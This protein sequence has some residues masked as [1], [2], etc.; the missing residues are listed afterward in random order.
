MFNS[1]TYSY[2]GG[3][4]SSTGIFTAPKSG[5]YLFTYNIKLTTSG[6]AVVSLIMNGTIITQAVVKK[7]ANHNG[8]NTG[9]AYVTKG[10]KVWVQYRIYTRSEDKFYIWPYRTTFNG[11]LID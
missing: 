10:G 6:E 5:T 1:V 2:G 3:Y 4:S 8:G 11:I 7:G 9:I